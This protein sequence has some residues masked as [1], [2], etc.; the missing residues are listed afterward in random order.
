MLNFIRGA[1]DSD[2]QQLV[3]NL[4][5]GASY[6]FVEAQLQ[7]HH[8]ENP[9]T[10]PEIGGYPTNTDLVLCPP[11]GQDHFFKAESLP[12][13]SDSGI[14]A[15][16]KIKDL[17]DCAQAG[18]DALIEESVSWHPALQVDFKH[19]TAAA[20]D[21]GGWTIARSNHIQPLRT[22]SGIYE[23]P[24][25]QV[26]T[27]FVPRGLGRASAIKANG[28]PTAIQTQQLSILEQPEWA[29]LP[30]SFDDG[31][32]LC[33]V[34]YSFWTAA[35][36]MLEEGVP[37]ASILGDDSPCVDLFFQPRQSVNSHNVDNWASS[38]MATFVEFERPMRLRSIYLLALLMKVGTCMIMIQEKSD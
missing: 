5:A 6:E 23:S 11:D 28:Y 30:I 31:S 32:P 19:D 37:A 17:E 26:M 8:D 12:D 25:N 35:R 14:G 22:L 29:I 15:E 24:Y 18:I 10:V 1:C 16:Q 13:L 27:S 2:V 20:V 7:A 3:T 33:R 9:T 21:S 36:T 34:F 4:R 38:L